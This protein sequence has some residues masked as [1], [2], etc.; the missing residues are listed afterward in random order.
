MELLSGLEDWLKKLQTRLNKGKETELE[1]RDA[2]HVSEV[3]QH[4]KVPSPQ[5]PLSSSIISFFHFLFL[6]SPEADD[7][8][9]SLLQC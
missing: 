3:L 7:K 9:T 1:A 6:S 5:F 4:Y 8:H 2:A